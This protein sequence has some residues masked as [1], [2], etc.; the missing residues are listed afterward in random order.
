MNFRKTSKQPISF[1][2]TQKICNEI[3]WIGNDPSPL[4]KFPENS[5]IF[6]NP[7]VPYLQITPIIHR[8]L[9]EAQLTKNYILWR[10]K[11]IVNANAQTIIQTMWGLGF[12]MLG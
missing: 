4:W 7:S 6:V 5:S 1:K 9:I 3:F 2:I 8:K 11:I 10:L 12:A